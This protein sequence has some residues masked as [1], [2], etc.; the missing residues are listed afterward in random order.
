MDLANCSEGY[1]KL[2]IRPGLTALS[3]T[4]QTVQEEDSRGYVSSAL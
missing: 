3:P 2:S 1:E 4:A